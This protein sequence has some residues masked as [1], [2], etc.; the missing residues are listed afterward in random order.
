MKLSL[1]LEIT[2]EEIFDRE[3]NTV[4]ATMKWNGE[5]ADDLIET[6]QRYSH[7][8]GISFD[9]GMNELFELLL[10]GG[11][12]MIHVTDGKTAESINNRQHWAAAN[13]GHYHHYVRITKNNLWAMVYKNV[14]LFCF[15][16][17]GINTIVTTKH[18]LIMYYD[19]G[20]VSEKKIEVHNL[21][22]RNRQ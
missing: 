12:E 10:K 22:I 11:A 19:D 6:V 8:V 4:L 20:V 7:Y 9:T 13:P 21:K 2:G 16:E 17:M 14:P 3:M 1:L 15:G 5:S 18:T